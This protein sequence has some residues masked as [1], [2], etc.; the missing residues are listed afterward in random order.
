MSKPEDPERITQNRVVKFFQKELGYAYLGNW[1][2]RENNSHIEAGLL[3]AWL[4]KRGV[5]DALIERVFRALDEAQVMGAGR[6]LYDINHAIYHMLRYGVPVKDRAG[7]QNETVWLIDWEHIENNEFALAEE[8]SIR[9]EKPVAGHTK[10]PDVVLYINGIAVAVLELKRASIAI[11][12]GIRQN[13][14]NQKSEFIRSFFASIQM[15]MA[16]ND[17]QGLRYGMIETKAKY[18]LTWK[19]KNGDEMVTPRYSNRLDNDLYCL[20]RKE[21]LLEQMHDFIVFDA[22][23]K[24]T[25]RHNQYFGVKAAQDRIKKREGGI[26]WHTQGSGKSLTMVWLAKWIRE[27]IPNSR[28]LVIT[29]RT[30]LDDQ[31][32]KVFLGVEEHIYRTK[33]GMDLIQVLNGT[34][35]TLMCSLVHKFGQRSEKK[36]DEGFNTFISELKAQVFQNFRAKGD[37]FVFVDECHRTQSGKLH[38][39]MQNLLPSAMFIGFTGTPLLKKDKKT[40]IE[41]F[42][43]FIH[44]YKFDEAVADEVILDLRYEARDIDQ[45]IKQPEKIDQWFEAKTKG[46]TDFAVR[47]LKA[48]WGSMQK[49]YSSRSRLEQIVADILLDMARKPRLESGRG[50]A[51]LVCSSV[52]QACRMYEQFEN[53]ELKG[54]CAIITS[55]EPTSTSIKGEEAGEGPTE[56]LKK[57]SIYRKML[58][59]FFDQSEDE[60]A[61]RVEEFEAKVKE[62]FIEQPAQMKLLIVVDKLL[63]GFDAP[64]ATYLYIDK[65]MQDHGLFQAICRV[66]RLDGEDKD[67]GYIIDY[68]DLFKS[69]DKAI[70]DYTSDAFAAYDKSD[71]EGLLK[72]RLIEGKKDLDEALDAVRAACEGVE[73]P[74]KVQDYIHYFVKGTHDEEDALRGKEPLRVALYKLVSKLTRT[75]MDLANEMN[76]AGYSSEQAKQIQDEVKHYEHVKFA[77][78]QASGDYLDRKT[79]EPAMRNLLD[80]YIRAED[81]ETIAEFDE[82]GLVG[83]ILNRP[84]DGLGKIEDALGGQEAMSEAIENNIRRKI[85]DDKEL[86]PKYYEKM[87]ILLEELI[88]LRRIKAVEYR[89]Y[90]RRV[91]EL[92]TQAFKPEENSAN[93][94]PKTMNTQAKRALYDNLGNDEVLVSRMDEIIRKTKRA[95]WIGNHFKEKELL[96]ALKKELEGTNYSLE[97][98]FELIKLQREYH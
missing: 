38:Q 5:R 18:Y 35:E 52:Y 41:V 16:G 88:E 9:G 91:K 63:T 6:N 44:K 78:Q 93:Q 48:Q 75:Y 97:K 13:L 22:G 70:K 19:E 87:S 71:I 82:D 59:D 43:S 36:M 21:R 55:Y 94:Y 37:L 29:D 26:I 77:V 45:Y 95:D 46:L 11:E 40:S 57:Y 2:Y 90:L 65:S 50:N 76:E 34:Q 60:A 4:Q 20:C 64:P 10:R 89:E 17:S 86:N 31:I 47:K 69:L 67:Y 83:L 73:Q 8:V 25:C 24:K 58:A 23:A 81:S 56:A 61:K 27:N 80:M 72:N 49:L 1:Q 42:G 39:A 66:N 62:K 30:E 98:V 92:M 28:V 54:H 33:S 53:T 32:Q 51:M 14:D 84:N 85:I 7:E 79:L 96:N 74:K 68:K 12:D 3:K 15:V